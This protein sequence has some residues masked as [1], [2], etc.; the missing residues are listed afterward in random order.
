M[1]TDDFSFAD[2]SRRILKLFKSGEVKTPLSFVF[3]ALGIFA[4]VVGVVIYAPVKDD[5]KWNII[6]LAFGTIAVLCLFVGLFAW[7]RPK[8]L[9]YGESGHR[10]EYKME[11]GTEKKIVTEGQLEELM[12]VENKKQLTSL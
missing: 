7:F 6:V 10:A 8:N 4:I 9:V 11:Y 1:P 5:L 3:R 2:I 12:P